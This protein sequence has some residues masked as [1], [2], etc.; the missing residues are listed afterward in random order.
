MPTALITGASRGFG[1]AL[2]RDLV[3]SGY[4]LVIDGR[5]PRPLHRAAE[6]LR[7]LAPD[8]LDVVALAGDVTDAAHRDDL[9]SAV[10]ARARLDL[11]VNNAGAL[12]PSPLPALSEVPLQALRELFEVNTI[13]PLALIQALLPQLRASA[14]TVVNLTS[15]AAVEHYPG[16]G[17]YGA[18]KAALDHLGG[19]LREEQ[20]RIRVVTFDPGDLRTRMHQDAFPGEDIS[21]RPHPEEAVPALRH[22]LAHPTLSGR[23]RGPEL[24]TTGGGVL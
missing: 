17:P 16:W 13:A 6:E 5:D 20:P 4:D 22:V 15:D 14:G 3:T 8:H 23:I 2:A 21:D 7:Q 11:L 10:S 9:I 19:V 18:S 24:S 1:Y 12:G